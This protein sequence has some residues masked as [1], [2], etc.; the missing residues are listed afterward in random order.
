MSHVETDLGAFFAAAATA[1]RELN[2]GLAA[3]LPLV[4]VAPA[5]LQEG[6][7]RGEPAVVLAPPYVPTGDFV[8]ACRRMAVVI[9]RHQPA[10]AAG[11]GAVADGM[12]A[13]TEADVA[14]LARAVVQG[15]SDLLWAW[16]EERQ[17]PPEQL[18]M[19]TELAARPFLHAYARS[20]E[21]RFKPDRWRERYCPVCGR[22][23]NVAF[24]D[25][26]N[27]K[28]LHCPGCATQWETRRFHCSLCGH[29]DR[30]SLHFLTVEEWPAW[31]I[32]TCSKCQGYMKV[33]DQ[34]EPGAWSPDLDL[35]V[36]DGQT[37]VLDM[38]AQQRGFRK[39]ELS[40]G[41]GH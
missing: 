20:L 38:A 21:G 8:A 25:G 9:G 13:A 22:R 37:L 27:R 16:C 34:R 15:S 4:A 18:Y 2:P 6:L 31:R 28:Y 30:G 17:L 41:V 33:M 19:V 7:S 11:A 3:V 26:E 32:E 5:A 36:A 10:A 35:F 40:G 29:D 12:A 14:D 1:G 24:V 23:P 39:P